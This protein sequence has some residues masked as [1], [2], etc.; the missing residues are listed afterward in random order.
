MNGW[1]LLGGFAAALVVLDRK[2]RPTD[3]YYL[4]GSEVPGAFSGGLTKLGPS[5]PG[6]PGT[7]GPP[8]PILAPYQAPAPPVA[9]SQP[10]STV[11]PGTTTRSLPTTQPQFISGTGVFNPP[12]PLAPIATRTTYRSS[13][14]AA[15]AG[16]STP[17][18]LE[19][20]TQA[21]AV[22]VQ[23]AAQRTAQQLVASFG[24][25]AGVRPVPTVR[26]FI[27]GAGYVAPKPAPL[28]SPAPTPS[29]SGRS[30]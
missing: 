20:A 22:Y 13:D 2:A 7:S 19:K 27:P 16:M 28:A 10:A 23:S 1:L 3:A 8:D 12:A 5:D 14:Y 21:A 25:Q 29:K 17:I 9:S 18:G 15:V 30:L 24:T 26:Q 6:A 4:P 11:I